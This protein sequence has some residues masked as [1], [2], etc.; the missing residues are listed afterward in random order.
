MLN[1]INTTLPLFCPRRDCKFYGSY[2]NK[3]TKD[4]VYITK[5]D[6]V[7]RQMFYCGRGKHR[8]SETGYSE[9]TDHLKSTRRPR[10]FFHTGFHA[11][12]LPMSLKRIKEQLIH[13]GKI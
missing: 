6:N 13:G 11:I 4:G 12:K 8:F 10:S 3:I 1:R 2:D 9:N 5:N 7:K